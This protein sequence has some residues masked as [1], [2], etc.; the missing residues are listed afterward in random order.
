M[1]ANNAFAS[2]FAFVI[3]VAPVQMI[4][5]GH[6]IPSLI[7]ADSNAAVRLE[8]TNLLIPFIERAVTTAPPSPIKDTADQTKTC[9][10]INAQEGIPT[11]N[12]CVNLI[13]ELND[14]VR[15]DRPSDRCFT[16]IGGKDE[17]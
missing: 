4:K 5:H 10:Y 17:H 2:L 9:L 13:K 6:R 7:T 12:A 14:C 15:A 1:N 16:L 11:P 3:S 8:F